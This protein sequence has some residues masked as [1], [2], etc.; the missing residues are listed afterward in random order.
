MNPAPQN[1][2]DTSLSLPPIR[3]LLH[4]L[5]GREAGGA[6]GGLGGGGGGAV[7]EERG[8]A[9]EGGDYPRKEVQ[10]QDWPR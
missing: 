10:P 8:Y 7:A 9:I 3:L 5:G 1:P 6:G 2:A 4:S